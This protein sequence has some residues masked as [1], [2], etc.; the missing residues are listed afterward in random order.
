V[1]SGLCFVIVQ[2]LSPDHK[3]HMVELLSKHTTMP[4]VLAE[5]GMAL[6]RDTVY[7]IPPKK[8]LTVH[9]M[10]LRLA[11]RGTG[12]SLPVDILF[13]SLAED[14]GERAAGVV[15]S[16]TGSDGMRGVRA[17]K[18][19]GGLVV[20][21]EPS[22]AKFDGMPR[23]AISVG[24]ADYVLP[25]GDIPE[26]L[27]QYAHH[28][29]Q[30]RIEL[31][32]IVDTHEDAFGQL[33]GLLRRQTGV[34]F[35]KYKP[36]TLSRRIQRRMAIGQVTTI[37]DYVALAR[38]SS[39]EVAALFKELLISVTKFFR[40]AESFDVLRRDVIPAML[41]NT[42]PGESVRVWVSGCATGEEAYSLA[43]LFEEHFE[44][45]GRP[46]DV[47]V[48]ATDIDREALEFAGAGIYPESIAADV[49]ADRLTR[50]FVRRGD[51]YQVA[52]FLRQRVVFANHDLTRDPPFSRVSLISCR[53]LLIYFTPPLQSHV[54]SSFRFALRPGGFLFLGSSETVGE[55][56]DDLEVMHASS[57]IFRRTR[58]PSRVP[59]LGRNTEP[60]IIPIRGSLDRH[61]ALP[62]GAHVV[63]A[64]LDTLLEAF[65][66][67]TILVNDQH[68]IL[69]VFGDP[70]PLLKLPPGSATLNLLTMLPKAAA[71][72]VSLGSHRALREDVACTYRSVPTE[73]GQVSLHVRPVPARGGSRYLLVSIE[74]ELET[75]KT[76]PHETNV[77]AEA[78]QQILDLQ[79]ELQFSRENLQATIEELETSNEELQATNE[80]LVASNEELQ[81]TNEELQ[82]VNEELHTLNSEYQQKITELVRLNDDIDN[83]LR[84]ARIG[85]VF[86]DGELNITR[87]TPAVREVMNLL[88]RD[89]GRPITHLSLKFDSSWFFE[90][91]QTVL[92]TKEPEDHEFLM[93]D[94]RSFL[95]RVEPY[96]S[97]W[98]TTNGLVVTA[99]DLTPVKD[100]ER[101]LE[102]VIDGLPQQVALVDRHGKITLVNKAWRAF[103]AANGGRDD[104]TSG[105]GANYLSVCQHPSAGSPEIVSIGEQL[106]ELLAGRTRELHIE[107]PCHTATE[108]RWFL[109]Q[110]NAL[111]GDS[112]GAVISHVNITRRKRAE[113]ELQQEISKH[114]GGGKDA[115]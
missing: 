14:L 102:R 44:D 104:K 83:L 59:E 32:K 25:V 68:D 48:F 8:V 28:S 4:V 74:M 100:A 7:L 2:H 115:G 97:E 65:A 92:S 109:M 40:D 113:L 75:P 95:L 70:S 93:P 52:R 106:G 17:L 84:S 73:R 90:V 9:Q 5:D 42:R 58:I 91:L 66:P 64:G 67:P 30:T 18:E 47:K 34:D 98:A 29:A 96:I 35:S 60:R 89:I 62:A 80:E 71:S 24:I 38:R 12:L 107:Y 81:S 23:A 27:Q 105:V 16:G 87:F 76:A 15:L 46:R 49:S 61:G 94:G 53:N 54:L 85:I 101:R 1:A 45:G 114:A 78:Q 22:T 6:D 57:K 3:S 31:P 55:L 77:A 99:L 63:Q 51:A 103:A 13:R 111:A 72:L 36:T 69:H 108:Q 39:T 86:L 110:A 88:D 112:G 50:F 43:M 41:E 19:A 26:K 56:G 10:E 79:Q 82:S 11:E 33:I 21:Q 20:V 37:E